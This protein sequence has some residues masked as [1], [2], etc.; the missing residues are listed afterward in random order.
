MNEYLDLTVIILTYNEEKHIGR[1][2]DNVCDIAN[3]IIVIDCFSTDRTKEICH[4]FDKV[5]FI[6]HHWPGN[7]SEQLNWALENVSINSKWLLRLDADEYMTEELKLEIFE[8]LPIIEED[9]SAILLP[10]GRVFHGKE[11][12]HGISNGIKMIRLFRKDAVRCEQRLMDEH[13]QV[14]KGRTIAFKNK[15]VDDS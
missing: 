8:K 10:L 12:K 14:L 11:L 5:R 1:C 7:Q 6:E 15:F 13:L 3:E 4:S 2:L 9:V